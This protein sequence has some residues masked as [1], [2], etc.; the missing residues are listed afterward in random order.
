[1]Q[2]DESLTYNGGMTAMQPQSSMFYGRAMPLDEALVFDDGV[3]LT[4]NATTTSKLQLFIGNVLQLYDS[5]VL[6]ALTQDLE[7]FAYQMEFRATHATSR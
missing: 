2:L 4:S 1:M 6:D 7:S 3:L 5:M